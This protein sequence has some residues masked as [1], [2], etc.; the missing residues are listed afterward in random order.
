MLRLFAA[1]LLFLPLFA[2]ADLR[3]LVPEFIIKFIMTTRS[4]HSYNSSGKLYKVIT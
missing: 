2:N 4:E 3:D 1:L